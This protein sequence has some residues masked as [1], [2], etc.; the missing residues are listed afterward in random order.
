MRRALILFGILILAST[1]ALAHRVLLTD[2]SSLEGEVILLDESKL[3]LET[4]FAGKLELDRAQVAAI[5]LDETALP[6]PTVAAPAA[7]KVKPRPAGQG[8]LKLSIQGDEARSSVRYQRESEREAMLALNTLYLRV[9]SDG[10]LVH[11]E[12]DASVDK[13]YR[14]GKWMVLRNSHLFGP[15]ELTLPAGEQR[16]QIVVGNDPGLGGTESDQDLVS[17]EV[18]VDELLVL[19]DQSIH[20]VLRGR[21]GRLGSYGHYELEVLS[22]R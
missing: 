20:M 8:T 7:E 1:G 18:T 11:E 16:L 3:V 14:R 4:S 2:G 19:P 15:L 5:Y 10:R 9:Y 6:A 22:S 21:A 12:S 17:A 13:E